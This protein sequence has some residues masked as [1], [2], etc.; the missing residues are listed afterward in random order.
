MSLS[1]YEASVPVFTRAFANLSAILAKGEAHAAAAGVD[2]AEL[3]TARLAPDM[4]TLAG[5][6]QRASD[7]AKGCG[8]RLAGV[9]NPSFADDEA[10][11]AELQARIAKTVDFLR[12]LRPEQFDGAEERE[13]VLPLAKQPVIFTGRSY[14]LT[15][16]MPNVFFH[17]TTAYAI[18]RHKGVAVGKLDYLGRP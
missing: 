4:L 2:P 8:A 11:F 5:Q 7:S 13:I 12:S 18:L 6:I 14:L 15:F 1:M 10:S 9:E 3:G 17:V 16:A